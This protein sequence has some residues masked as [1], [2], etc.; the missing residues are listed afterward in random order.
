MSS[1]RLVKSKVFATLFF[2]R[3]GAPQRVEVLARYKRGLMENVTLAFAHKETC[4]NNTCLREGL[5]VDGK[6]ISFPADLLGGVI[7]G[8]KG[9]QPSPIFDGKYRIDQIVAELPY[10]NAGKSKR[11]EVIADYGQRCV[12]N[13][14]FSFSSRN[15]CKERSCDVGK[16]A[17]DLQVCIAADVLPELIASFIKMEQEAT[18]G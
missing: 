5:W 11:L 6:K 18:G 8:L 12:R 1:L 9:I 16:W 14:W 7:G 13:V 15:R 3:F 17:C 4:E 10:S 2:S